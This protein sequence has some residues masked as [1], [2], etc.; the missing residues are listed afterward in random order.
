MCAHKQSA[1]DCDLY[2]FSDRLL[3]ITERGLMDELGG[4]PGSGPALRQPPWSGD[5]GGISLLTTGL[6][7][8]FAHWNVFC[9]TN[10]RSNLPERVVST[11]R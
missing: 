1:V 8:L 2:I 4:G 6:R 11:D 5:D 3:V 7:V 9:G 10:I